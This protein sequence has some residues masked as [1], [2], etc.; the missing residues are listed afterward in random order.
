M[1][2]GVLCAV[3]PEKGGAFPKKIL[4]HDADRYHSKIA[5][6]SHNTCHKL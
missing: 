6:F 2:N 5:K 4:Q 1:Q 3:R